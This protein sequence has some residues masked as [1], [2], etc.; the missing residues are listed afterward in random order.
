M[1]IAVLWA[2]VKNVYV[3]GKLLHYVA[4][5]V[6]ELDDSNI[7]CITDHPGFSPVCLNVWVLQTSSKG[8]VTATSE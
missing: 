8:E 7:V 4:S 3:A 1:A 2:Q 5:K 6:D